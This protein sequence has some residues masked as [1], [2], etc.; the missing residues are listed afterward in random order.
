M[1]HIQAAKNVTNAECILAVMSGTFLQRGEPAIIDK[2]HRTKAAL[3]SGVDI[4]VELPYVYAVQSS[5]WFAKGAVHSLYHLGVDSICFGSEQGEI[6]YFRS[7]YHRLKNSQAAFKKELY[8]YLSKGWAFPEASRKGYEKIGLSDLQIDLSKPN[9]ILGFS[10]VKEVMEHNLP[11]QLSTIKRINSDYHDEKITGSITSATSI[12]NDL[13]HTKR[14]SP[15]VKNALPK[16]S[17][18][19]L[20]SYKEIATV[21][22]SWEDYFP[23]LQ[24]RVMTMT[25]DE[26]IQIHGIAEG[27]EHRIKRTAKQVSSFQEWMEAIKTKRYTWTRI[28]R[29]FVNI[30]TNTK[31]AEIKHILHKPSVPYIRLLG[32]TA[33]GQAYLNEKKKDLSIPLLSSLKRD[34]HPMLSIEERASYAYYS[35]LPPQSKNQLVHEELTPPLIV[36]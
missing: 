22:H 18:Q 1:Y 8:H 13:F 14:I 29:I 30:L 25:I 21:W 27:L 9:N 17:I 34:I 20:E 7:A 26:L 4:V 16:S 2:F 3:T 15:E 5:E 28:Q 24:Y 12:R 36:Q 19:Q 11:I 23:L 32:L 6:Q 10:Y 33:K 35:M 31:T